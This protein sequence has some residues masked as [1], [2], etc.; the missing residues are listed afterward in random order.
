MYKQSVRRRRAVLALLVVASLLLLTAYFGESAGGPFHA[1]QRGVLQVTAPIQ[2][3]ASRALKPFRDLFGWVGDTLDARSERDRLRNERNDLRRRVIG[4]QAAEREN[5]QLRRLVNLDRS[6]TLSGYQPVTA[7]VIGR[8]PTVWYAT[9]TVDRG[10]SDG[11]RVDQP[12]VSG[13]GLVGKVTAVT[14]NASQVTLI[15]DSTS[16]VS[17]RVLTPLVTA[18][19]NGITGVVQPAVGRPR[20][21]LLEFVP[22]RANISK[23]DTV[24]TAGSRSTR[25]ES[26]FPANLPIGVVTQADDQELSQYQ[27][28]HVRPFADL[29]RLD[30]VQILTRGGGASSGALRAQGG[31]P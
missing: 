5:A 12:V 16:G 19:G 14:G 31:T 9:I 18:S 21:L 22:R 29:R 20:D 26:L 2:E 15:T 10:Q 25:L 28:V 3:G 13:E 7:R 30:F 17:A 11:V 23:G 4:A 24:V 8:S 27:R 1:L 6:N